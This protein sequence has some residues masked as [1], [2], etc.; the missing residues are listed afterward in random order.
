MLGFLVPAFAAA[1]MTTTN[2]TAPQVTTPEYVFT[3]DLPENNFVAYEIQ[4]QDTLKKLAVLRYGNESYWTNLWNDNPSITNPD[5]IQ[6]GTVLKI[7]ITMPEK[8]AVL[9]ADLQ[10]RLPKVQPIVQSALA[11]QPVDAPATSYDDVYRAAGAKYG[12]PWQILYGIHMTETGGRNGH[13]VSHLGNGPEGPM[14]FMPG[15]FAAYAVDGNGDG[16]TD[17]DDA[18]DA[19]YTAANYLAKHGSLEAGLRSYGGNTSGTLSYARARG[20]TQ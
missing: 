16:K 2:Q 5:E 1:L 9:S 20:Y 17:I 18:T 13:I 3:R 14:Q 15:T 7:R 19:I 11:V 10:A 4:P 6:E 8:P 12:I